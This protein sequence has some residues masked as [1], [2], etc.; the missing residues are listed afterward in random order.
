MVMELLAILL[1]LAAI[2]FLVT[3]LYRRKLK[4]PQAVLLIVFVIYA[5]VKFYEADVTALL[6]TWFSAVMATSLVLDVLS[7]L[8]KQVNEKLVV[9]LIL[10]VI[11]GGGVL[12]NVAILP[13][14]VDL[15]IKVFS[16]ALLIV[17][18]IPLLTAVMAYLM[19]KRTSSKRLVERFYLS[20]QLEEGC[21]RDCME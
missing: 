7:Y 1:I 12:V 2:G 9:V 11:S 13:S 18:H 14:P 10:I 4:L 16:L 3:Y 8:N 19:G 15:W 5:S 20:S 21:K 17:V 6:F